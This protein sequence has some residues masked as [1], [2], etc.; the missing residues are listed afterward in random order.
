MPPS[1]M[2]TERS[3]RIQGIRRIIIVVPRRF[4]RLQNCHF[5]GK[6]FC[7]PCV[8][9]LCSGLII[10]CWQW[11]PVVRDQMPCNE[12]APKLPHV[13]RGGW[14]VPSRR[15]LALNQPWHFPERCFG[16]LDNWC[17]GDFL[18]RQ[19]KKDPMP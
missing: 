7:L 10:H 8:L 2:E 18:N 1:P 19:P 5:F 11:F 15:R 6:A 4:Y 13:S 9:A 3:R 12:N 14:I 16:T 17:D